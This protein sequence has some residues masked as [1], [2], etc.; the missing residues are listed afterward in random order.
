VKKE[1][2]ADLAMRLLRGSA[3][4]GSA[5]AQFLLGYLYFTSADVDL[6]ESKQ[7]LERAAA[8]GHAE[9]LF[10]LSDLNDDGTTGPPDCDRRRTL[11]V[12]AAELGSLRAQRDLGCYYAIGEFG[13]PL[14][15]RLGRLWYSRAAERGHADAQFNYGMMVINGEGGPA[16]QSNGLEWVRRAAAQNDEAA[17]QYLSLES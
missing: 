9:A 15:H 3:D 4:A 2:K 8:Q 7:W 11:L 6:A 16:D 14:D 12:R 1:E 5:E 13:F 10:Y 17:L